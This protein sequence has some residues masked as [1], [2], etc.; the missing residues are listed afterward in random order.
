MVIWSFIMYHQE[1]TC[2]CTLFSFDR[3][4]EIRALVNIDTELLSFRDERISSRM[5]LRPLD[6]D[7]FA[8]R[9]VVLFLVVY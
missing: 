6:I 9:A 7:H 3:Y 8:C 1:E 4:V 5:R 2:I